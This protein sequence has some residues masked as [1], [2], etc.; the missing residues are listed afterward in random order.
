MSKLR[1]GTAGYERTKK[2]LKEKLVIDEIT[3]IAKK[4]KGSI[5]LDIKP[6]SIVHGKIFNDNTVQMMSHLDNKKTL[7]EEHRNLL[8]VVVSKDPNSIHFAEQQQSSSTDKRKLANNNQ[9]IYDFAKSNMTE[10]GLGESYEDKNVYVVKN[11]TGVQIA[12]LVSTMLRSQWPKDGY[13]DLDKV[14][15]PS[16]FVNYQRQLGFFT[17]SLNRGDFTETDLLTSLTRIAIVKEEDIVTKVSMGDRDFS[18]IDPTKRVLPIA[19]GEIVPASV[20]KT[21]QGHAQYVINTTRPGSEPYVDS[22]NRVEFLNKLGFKL[23]AF[24]KSINDKQSTIALNKAISRVRLD[25][26]SSREVDLFKGR[27]VEFRYTRKFFKD[28]PAIDKDGRFLRIGD[29][30]QYNT[31]EVE[32]QYIRFDNGMVM[33]LADDFESWQEVTTVLPVFDNE[34]N[35]YNKEVT[36][37]ICKNATDGA[38]YLSDRVK[39]AYFDKAFSRSYGGIQFR[40]FGYQKGLAVFVPNL[41]LMTGADIVS[42][43]GSR[44]ASLDPYL[45]G[46]EELTFSVVNVTREPKVQETNRFARQGMTNAFLDKEMTSSAYETSEKHFKKAFEFDLETLNALIGVEEIQ[47]G[48]KEG[49]NDMM[50][51]LAVSNDSTTTTYLS[52]NPDLAL[53]SATLKDKTTTL[54]SS[55]TKDFKNG[56][57]FLDDAY[58]RHMVVDP[59]AIL[60]YMK[61]GKI[62]VIDGVGTK[63]G[64]AS[65]NVLDI[66]KRLDGTYYLKSGNALL[67]RYPNL[68]KREVIKTGKNKFY[69]E[70]TRQLYETYVGKGYFKGL[71]LFSLWDMNPEGMSGADYDGDTCLIIND[72][73]LVAK[74]K[75]GPLFL[76]YSLVQDESGKF[77]IVEGCPFSTPAKELDIHSL[78]PKEKYNLISKYGLSTGSSYGSIEFNSFA[79]Y[80]ENKDEFLDLIYP[81]IQYFILVNLKGNDIG[82]YTNLLTTVTA[83]KS[84]VS[85]DTNTALATLKVLEVLAKQNEG[86]Q[87]GIDLL[88]QANDVLIIIDALNRE[89]KGYENL[90]IL[91]TATV[92]W[93]ID[94]AKHGGA[95]RDKFTFLEA[96][97]GIDNEGYRANVQHLMD[98]EDKFDISLQ[99]L[100]ANREEVLNIVE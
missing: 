18:Y 23:D 69:D 46:N 70:K 99:R 8:I 47:I 97:D 43:D 26:A 28:V 98:I 17:P 36:T 64:I 61:A 37:A 90:Q 54:V 82:R 9:T 12:P 95:Y 45:D 96:F 29:E 50:S 3:K 78:I 44:K 81:I 27:T 14:I 84:E 83:I 48:D 100:F 51:T 87:A 60:S 55:I 56:H 80:E 85:A 33:A 77:E 52:S 53:K 89:Y 94:A 30:I 42:F 39:S 88:S 7:L 25:N 19:F 5:S 91:L 65:D 49:Y 13:P 79:L 40:A 59:I 15:D 72:D 1:K 4:L 75:K 22:I 68:D 16:F 58:T 74:F 38:I 2:D 86:T 6:E 57:A 92:R 41:L 11:E 93:E 35:I 62:G 31:E 10:L 63:I 66:G 20:G 73:L 21:R 34:G 32:V 76:D 24:A 67:V 71:V